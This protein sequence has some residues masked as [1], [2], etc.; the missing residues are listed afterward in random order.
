MISVQCGAYRQAFISG[1][2]LNPRAAK[3]SAAEKFTVGYA[4]ER[5]TAGHREILF[6]HAFV[7][8]QEKLEEHFFEAVLHG[9]GEIHIALCNFGVRLARRAEEFFHLAAEM[10]CQAHGSIGQD[11]HSLVASERLE[12]AHVELQ[13]S[14]LERENVLDLLDV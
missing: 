3:G 2:G 10:P 1:S 7:Q 9:V 12:V 4:I 8:F 14:I 6:G 13:I 5:A 11:L